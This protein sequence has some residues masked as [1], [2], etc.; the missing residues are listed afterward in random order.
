MVAPPDFQYHLWLPTFVGYLAMAEA[1]VRM[2]KTVVENSVGPMLKIFA[3]FEHFQ[4]ML[5]S[6]RGESGTRILSFLK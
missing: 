5:S 4:G 6:L 3:F 1:S 2:Q